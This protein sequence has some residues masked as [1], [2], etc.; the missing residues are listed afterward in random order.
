MNA[1]VSRISAALL[2]NAIIGFA[3]IV[4]GVR[5]EWQGCQPEPR[6]RIYVGNHTSHGDFLLIWAVLPE[7]L[8]SETR[9]VAAADYWGGAGLR[10]FVGRVVFRAAL[11]E[12]AGDRANGSPIETL[13]RVL[14]SG[15]S[16]IFFPE[17]TRNTGE[18]ALLP[19][20]S[21]IFHLA[22]ACPDVEIVPVWIDNV[23]RVMPKGEFL[24]VPLLC[25]VTFGKPIALLH[26]E[27]KTDFLERLRAGLLALAPPETLR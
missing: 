22:A 23:S 17:G 13:K 5:A 3:R 7:A 6:Q 18:E 9:P 20:K 25:K 11:V 1:L 19:L 27:D 24:P 8:R 12:R 16:L 26:A 14:E 10:G 4:T 21:G 15:A 2:S